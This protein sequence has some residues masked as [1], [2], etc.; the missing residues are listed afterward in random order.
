MSTSK[1]RFRLMLA[2]ILAAGVFGWSKLPAAAPESA[3]RHGRRNNAI[4]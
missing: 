3:R 2:G 1:I 4:N